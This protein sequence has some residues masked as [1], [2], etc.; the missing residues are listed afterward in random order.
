MTPQTDPTYTHTND[1]LNSY[2]SVCVLSLP[3][4]T[5]AGHHDSVEWNKESFHQP[6][7]HLSTVNM[8]SIHAKCINI[9][10]SV[11]SEEQEVSSECGRL[12]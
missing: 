7:V 9:R 2:I 4:S 11:L 1:K 8:K 5:E 3:Y 12:Q 10:P 6:L